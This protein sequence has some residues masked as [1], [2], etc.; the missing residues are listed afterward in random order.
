MTA[1]SP[2]GNGIAVSVLKFWVGLGPLIAGAWRS[3][4]LTLKS[5]STMCNQITHFMHF[6]FIFHFSFVPIIPSNICLV[7]NDFELI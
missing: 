7:S 3:H 1:P 2:Q 6:W 5:S 4:V